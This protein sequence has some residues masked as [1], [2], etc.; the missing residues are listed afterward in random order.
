[1]TLL[2]VLWSTSVT[3]SG[4][5]DKHLVY[6]RVMARRRCTSLPGPSYLV[7]TLQ[8]IEQAQVP[9]AFVGSTIYN[10]GGEPIGMLVVQISPAAIDRMVT[11]NRAWRASGR[12]AT[13]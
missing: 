1:M 3:L 10:P 9:V 8:A 7:Q 2:Q 4:Y 13:G 5:G 6:C 11:D 12:G